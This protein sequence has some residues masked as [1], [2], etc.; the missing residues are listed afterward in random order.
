M[1]T[2][3]PKINRKNLPK[4]SQKYFYNFLMTDVIPRVLISFK[5]MV[6]QDKYFYNKPGFY[7]WY[8]RQIGVEWEKCDYIKVI[9]MA[10]IAL[11]QK[12]KI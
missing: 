5:N 7:K 1:W 2:S 4:R 8:V 10:T 12:E 3:K 6:G 9:V 11:F